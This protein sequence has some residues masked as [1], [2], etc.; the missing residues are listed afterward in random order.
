MKLAQ[1]SRVC[2]TEQLIEKV[3]GVEFSSLSHKTATQAH[4]GKLN[5]GQFRTD[6]RS[7]QF[8]LSL[9]QNKLLIS[10]SLLMTTS[11][12]FYLQ[13]QRHNASVYQ[14]LGTLRGEEP[15]GPLAMLVG[16]PI[17]ISPL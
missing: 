3:G 5:M 7:N 12:M 10:L 17:G 8:A 4:P 6:K 14:L 11:I 16:L 1:H 15:C 9:K 2:T 13:C